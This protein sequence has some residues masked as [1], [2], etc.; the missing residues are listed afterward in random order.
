MRVLGVDP[1]LSRCGAGVVDGPASRPTAV[2]VGVIRTPADA[3]VARRLATLHAEI[4][5]LIAASAPDAVAV[6]RVFFNA[7]VRTAMGVGQAA[8]VVLLAAEQAGVAVCEYTPT[9]VKAA[10]AGDGGADKGQVGYMVRALLRLA[11][12]PS[13]ADAADALALALCHLQRAGAPAG[14]AMHPRLAAAVEAAQPGAQ[15]RPL[16]G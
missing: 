4:G 1:G 7:N 13:P 12:T 14:G 10:V 6:E 16:S 2:R 3:P 11:A 8:G 5:A 15:V 9:Q